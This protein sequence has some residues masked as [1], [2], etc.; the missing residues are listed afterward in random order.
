MSPPPADEPDPKRLEASIR[1]S[2]VL[3]RVLESA[4][5]ETVFVVGGTVRD[6]LVGLPATDLDLVVEGPIDQLALSLDPDGKIHDRFETAEITLDGYT[7][8]IARART[9]SYPRAGA[10]PEVSPASLREDLGRRDFTINAMAV[11][12][13]QPGRLIDP[14]AGLEDLRE[15]RLRPVREGSFAEDPTRVIRAARY[16]TRFGLQLQPEAVAEIGDVELDTTSNDRLMSEMRRLVSEGDGK[17]ALRRLVDWGVGR[18]AAAG[19]PD[20]GPMVLEL[21]EAAP[22]QG[23]G[24]AA[25]FAKSWLLDQIEGDTSVLTEFEG[26][27]SEAVKVAAG[28]SPDSVLLARVRGAEWLDR[29]LTDWRY[30]KPAITGEDLIDR[31]V[32]EGRAVGAG[33]DAA[34]SAQ[35]DEDIRDFDSQ[36]EIALSAAGREMTG[37]GE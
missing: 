27:A 34:L 23:F 3:S 14:Y 7:V 2:A 1:E 36:M 19:A 32:P 37:D 30:A 8:D 6:M 24:D 15:G 28:H 16:V 11:A 13:D 5:G 25:G 31:G 20:E 35:L 21:L 26:Q 22:W 9:E 10:L 17:A 33:L 18:G 4:E 29:W 12:V